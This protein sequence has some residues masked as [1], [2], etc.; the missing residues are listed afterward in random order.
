[1]IIAGCILAVGVGILVL[2]VRNNNAGQRDFITYWAAGQQLIHGKDP[3][4]FAAVLPL[5]RS[6]GFNRDQA[7]VMRNP[8]TAFFMAFPLG[9]VGANTGLILWLVGLIAG[10]VASIRMIWA[11]NGRP[12]N[13]LHLIGY[14]FAPLMECL[15]TGQFGIFL[16][17]GVV[18]FLYFHK[19]RPAIAGAALL[20]C[21]VKP[22]LFV[23]FGIVLVLW[24][25]RTRAYRLL[26]AACIALASSCAFAFWVDPHAWSQYQ[27]M[28]RTSGIMGEIV[29]TL[30]EMLRQVVH[31]D[32]VWLQFIPEFAGCCWALWYFHTRR[33]RWDWMDQGL[34][35]LL[36][37]ILCSPYSLFT[38]E[39]LLLP[40]VLAGVYRAE[41]TRRSLIPFGLILAAAIFEVFINVP[42]TTVYY[43]WTIPAWLGWYLYATKGRTTVSG[44]IQA[45]PVA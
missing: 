39:A 35:L 27:Q 8:P 24:A 33:A 9:F 6:A 12:N 41:I 14:C 11:M 31:R 29:P 21:A 26:G 13:R 20:L 45:E 1:M 30:S 15:M 38:D 16:L 2:I 4:D 34:L 7:L 22:H 36:V 19:T 3:Y 32:A 42:I 5:E 40:A 44:E 10:L 23:P 25:I 18:L 28:M 37:S 17:L 43:L